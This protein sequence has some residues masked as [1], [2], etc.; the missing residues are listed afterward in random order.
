MV[1][2]P[3]SR[4]WR[5]LFLRVGLRRNGFTLIELLGVVALMSV[6]ASI[7][8][9]VLINMQMQRADRALIEIAAEQMARMAQAAQRHALDNTGVWPGEA[10]ACSGA[11]TIL[12]SAG[13]IPGIP[14]TDPW[15]NGWAFTC[16]AEANFSVRAR[17]DNNTSAR[18]V[19]AGIA[20]AVVS[21]QDV[22]GN[23]PF[24]ILL[25]V[26]DEYMPLNGSRDMTGN[27]NMS[28]N[29]IQDASE[30]VTDGL[31]V[32]KDIMPQFVQMNAVSF[33]VDSYI[34][35]PVC[36]AGGE[37][38]ILLHVHGIKTDYI[39]NYGEMVYAVD[40]GANWRITPYAS[41]GSRVVGI[42]TTHCYYPSASGR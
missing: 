12:N 36:A 11:Y 27:L 21:G 33:N 9:P 17:A 37:P 1:I 38:R 6:L 22:T 35:K 29:R 13:R 15:G 5:T 10:S 3:P 26:L 31:R 20:G 34:D 2:H 4:A 40:N 16:V 7:M 23:W 41:W 19:A 28:N 30:I 42:A 14:A 39:F 32:T 8:G 24:P 25:P 18:L